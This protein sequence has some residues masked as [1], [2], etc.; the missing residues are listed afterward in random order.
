MAYNQNKWSEVMQDLSELPSSHK[1][2]GILSLSAEVI[3]VGT[4]ESKNE[5]YPSIWYKNETMVEPHYLGI[6]DAKALRAI[7]DLAIAEAE[8]ANG[9]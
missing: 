6:A 5:L 8:G 4:E 1:V 9:S 7:L 3:S 2:L